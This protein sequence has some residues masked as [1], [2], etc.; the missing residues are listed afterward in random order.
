LTEAEAYQVLTRIFTLVFE[1][2][3]IVLTPDLSSKDVFGWDSFKQ[4]EIIIGIEEALT[5]KFK[6]DEVDHLQNVGDL[7]RLI[8]LRTDGRS[9]GTSR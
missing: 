6:P 2:K 8:V 9:R 1:R 7:A 4:V 3:G 5:I